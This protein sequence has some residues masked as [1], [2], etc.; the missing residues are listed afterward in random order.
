MDESNKMNIP[1]SRQDELLEL[2]AI[3]KELE[4]GAHIDGL[5]RVRYGKEID[6]LKRAG[7]LALVANQKFI[8][9]VNSGKA[10]SVETYDDLVAVNIALRKAGVK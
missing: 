3:I 10:K 5:L 1:C 7:E 4:E 6:D 9:K 8:D 2:R